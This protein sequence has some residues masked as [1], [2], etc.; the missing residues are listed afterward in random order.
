M[1]VFLFPL[2]N[3]TLFPKTTKPLNVFESKYLEMIRDSVAKGTPVALGFIE[4]AMAVVPVSAGELVPYVR[5]IAGFGSAQ[6]VEERS[7]GT[8]LAFIQGQGKCR[9]GPVKATSSSY[10]VCEAEVLDEDVS[11][12]PML[13]REI[14]ALNKILIRWITTHIPDS[15][16]REI[17]V[18][19]LSGPEEIIGAFASYLVRDYD[20]QQMVLEF[21]S[22]SEKIR[23]LHRL[24]ESNEITL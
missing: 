18:R 16:Q 14:Q 24:A 11:V 19:N 13:A 12:D 6:I 8:L 21:D 20:L 5:P 9:L 1:D 3:V 15:S 22:V 2:V 10:L 4:D 23:F 17:F 7:N